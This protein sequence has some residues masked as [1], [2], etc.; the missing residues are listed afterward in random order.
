MDGDLEQSGPSSAVT[1]TIEQLGEHGGLRPADIANL[2][3][4]SKATVSQW[5][6][7]REVP[8]PSTQVVL[9]NL[10]YVV[11]SLSEFYARDEIRLWL[12]ERNDLLKGR[13]ALDLIHEGETEAVLATIECLGDLAYF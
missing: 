8:E 5:S 7:G 1:R 9:S 11:E 12:N 3:G 13:R 4:V 6:V 10:R 2:T